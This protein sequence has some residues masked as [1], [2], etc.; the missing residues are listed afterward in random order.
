M[1]QSIIKI[2]SKLYSTGS[3]GSLAPAY[4]Q[5]MVQGITRTGS[6]LSQGWTPAYH[7]D[8]LNLSHRLAQLITRR[9]CSSLSQGLAPAKDK[10]WLQPIKDWLQPITMIGS[11]LPQGLTP[12][13][14]NDWLQPITRIS[15]SLSQEYPQDCHKDRLHPWLQI[16]D[17]GGPSHKAI[18]A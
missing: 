12:A 16:S 4:Y 8:M 17:L 7:K 13:H 18:L 9:M 15:S 5:D 11:S 2:G 10:N 6:S 3:I 1:L 14:H